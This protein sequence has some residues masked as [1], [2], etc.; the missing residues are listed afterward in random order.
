MRVY[1]H[2]RNG[3]R[4]VCIYKGVESMIQF[5]WKVKGTCCQQ[6][7]KTVISKRKVA[8]LKGAAIHGSD[9]IVCNSTS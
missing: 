3:R 4:S 1:T 7:V 2:I 6:L 8:F 5:S 9:G